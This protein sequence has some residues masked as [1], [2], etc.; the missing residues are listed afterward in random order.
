MTKH[1]RLDILLDASQLIKVRA[2]QQ[3]HHQCAIDLSIAKESSGEISGGSKSN[4]KLEALVR[5]KMLQP[6]L[7]PEG[8]R[9]Y[10]YSKRALSK[11]FNVPYHLLRPAAINADGFSRSAQQVLQRNLR[12]L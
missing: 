11:M 9:G 4:N 1:R 3:G 12:R 6:M 10:Y 7:R 8:D 2:L 5:A